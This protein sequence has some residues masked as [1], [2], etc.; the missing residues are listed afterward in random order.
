MLARE[1]R[2]R[3]RAGEAGALRD[4]RGEERGAVLR[5]DDAVDRW[6]AVLGHEPARVERVVVLVEI[7]PA[8]QD[9]E[10]GGEPGGVD[11]TEVP[12]LRAD[13]E[14]LPQRVE[15]YG[16]GAGPRRLAT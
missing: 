7:G 14:N 9:L 13:E 6:H 2:T 5:P 4:Q 11:L 3:R 8:R 12:L 16:L 1:Q 10:L 15:S